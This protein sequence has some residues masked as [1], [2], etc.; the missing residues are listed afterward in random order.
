MATPNYIVCWGN[1]GRVLQVHAQDLP[2]TLQKA[3]VTTKSAIRCNAS[4]ELC[5]CPYTYG[6][7]LGWVVVHSCVG[8]WLLW[9][10]SGV[11]K[12][13]FTM[14]C[15]QTFLNNTFVFQCTGNFECVLFLLLCYLFIFHILAALLLY[16]R[17]CTT[18]K[19]LVCYIPCF[20]LAICSC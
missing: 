9:V 12:I 15:F 14:I 6:H 1:L 7:H 5:A 13:P 18:I 8:M 11:Y 19:W 4:I 3:N 2:T 16:I 20:S 10:L 17:T